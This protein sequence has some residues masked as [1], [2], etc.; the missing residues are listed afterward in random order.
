MVRPKLHILVFHSPWIYLNTRLESPNTSICLIQSSRVFSNPKM[1]ASYS[2]ILFVAGCRSEN[3]KRT[4][5]G[6]WSPWGDINKAYTKNPKS[7]WGN[8]IKCLANRG[9]KF[10]MI[11]LI[12]SLLDGISITCEI[13][14]LQREIN[15]V[16]DSFGLCLKAFNSLLETLTTVLNA[17]CLKNS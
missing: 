15:E 13:F 6:M 12:L 14:S 10:L 4:D 8:P 11:I 3:A 17:N 5:V 7:I 16:T 9:Y 1:Q 2:T